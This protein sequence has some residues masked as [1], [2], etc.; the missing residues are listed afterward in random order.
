MRVS[1]Q[2]LLPTELLR[3]ACPE[4]GWPLGARRRRWP[5]PSG[6]T[7]YDPRPT[8]VWSPLAREALPAVL[9]SPA[10]AIGSRTQSLSKALRVT[11]GWECLGMDLG[12]TRT[13]QQGKRYFH[14]GRGD[15]GAHTDGDP[16]QPLFSG[17]RGLG[18]AGTTQ[19]L[20]GHS[21]RPTATQLPATPRPWPPSPSGE[22]PMRPE[23]W[24]GQCS[25]GQS[26][27]RGPAVD[28]WGF[29]PLKRKARGRQAMCVHENWQRRL[30]AAGKGKGGHWLGSLAG[31]QL[32]ERRHFLDDRTVQK[33]TRC[34]CKGVSCLSILQELADTSH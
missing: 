12:H 21:C 9:S 17:S 29:K 10:P 34:F 25:A 22:A 28:S 4:R 27:S 18:S 20:T 30:R 16:A 14:K 32:G 7:W 11:R 15:D 3:E 6:A 1:W 2:R 5:A 31:L 19:E 24:Q 13:C 33:Q 23:L 26:P 8:R